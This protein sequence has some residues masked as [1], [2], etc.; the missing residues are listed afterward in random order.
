MLISGKMK[1]TEKQIPVENPYTGEI[2]DYVSHA[3]KD[4]VLSAAEIAEQGWQQCR[5]LSRFERA[6]ILIKAADIVKNRRSEFAKMIVTEAG[7]TITQAWKE[8]D[9]CINTL[10]LSAEEAKRHNGET[11]PFDAYEGS[12]NRQGYYTKEPLGII[13]AITP[14]NDP[15]NLVAHKI[16]PAVACG[17]SILLKPSELAPFSAIKLCEVMLEAGYPEQ[18]LSVLTGDAETGSAIVSLPKV[19]MVSFTGGIETGKAIIK[20][21]GLKKYAMDL[22]GNAPVIILEDCDLEKAVEGCVSGSFW[23]AG[24]NCIGSQRLLIEKGIYDDFRDAFISQTKAMTVGNP[25]DEATDMGPMITE[26]AAIRAQ[27]WV[28]KAV[29]EGANLLYGNDRDKSLFSPTVLDNV[30]LHSKVLCDEV[31]APIVNFVAI[32]NMD[33]AIMIA[34]RPEYSLHAGI[35]TKDLE[36]ALSAAD[37]IE[38]SGIMINDSSD[39]RF[40]AMP[41]GGFKYGGLGREGVRFA[42]DEMSQTKVICFNRG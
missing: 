35:F 12:E 17:N 33:E 14:F 25:M 6:N 9:R 30:P 4:D 40:D 20:T 38:A 37:R 36:R 5:N 2:I 13:A 34:N 31:F 21:A 32:E 42:M 23:A 29:E 1:T 8:V 15:L 39:Y 7:K 24:Q 22:G 10:T 27:S 41:F 16:G 26:N 28:N 3:T 19:R 18:A 11:I